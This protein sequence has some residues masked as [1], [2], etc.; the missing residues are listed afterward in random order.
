M[1]ATILG[2]R[3]R[4]TCAGGHFDEGSLQHTAA[5]C[6]LLPP[7]NKMS[8]AAHAQSEAARGAEAAGR[9]ALMPAGRGGE[10]LGRL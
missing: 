8:A 1:G 10:G 6:L 2:P 7:L 3:T 5:T 9:P 4:L